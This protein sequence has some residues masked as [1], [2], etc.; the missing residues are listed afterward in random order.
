MQ[1]GEQSPLGARR[2]CLLRQPSGG[3]IL[4]DYSM[5]RLRASDADALEEFRCKDRPDCLGT[6]QGFEIDK[7]NIAVLNI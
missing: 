4:C 2:R 5:E 7:A 6:G 1:L 3:K